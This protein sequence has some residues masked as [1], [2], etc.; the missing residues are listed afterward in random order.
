MLGDIKDF[1]RYAQEPDLDG[2]SREELL[3]YLEAVHAQIDRLDEQEPEDMDSE[4]YE[5]WGDRHEALEDLADEILD[6]LDELGGRL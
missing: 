6:R 4:E 2:M 5:S 3:D 1:S